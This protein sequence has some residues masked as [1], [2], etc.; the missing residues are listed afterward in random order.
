MTFSRDGNRFAWANGSIVRM[1]TWHSD[2]KTWKDSI[3]G[4]KL[5]R[6]T[7]MQFSPN[8]NIL[9]TWEVFAKRDIW[10]YSAELYALCK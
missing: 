7:Y 2:S 9:A 5:E 1:A 3:I 4:E 8:G 10:A 6:T